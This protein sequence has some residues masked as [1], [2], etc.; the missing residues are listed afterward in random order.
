MNRGGQQFAPPNPYPPASQHVPH[1][2]VPQQ[3]KPSLKIPSQ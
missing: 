1:F 2:G 3:R